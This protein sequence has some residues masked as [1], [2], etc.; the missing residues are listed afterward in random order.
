MLP[1]SETAR[2]LRD[3]TLDLMQLLDDVRTRMH[4]CEQGFQAMLPEEGRFDRLALEAQSLLERYP[5]PAKRPPLFGIPVAVKDI[6]HVRGFPTKAGSALPPEALY[7]EEGPVIQALRSAGA[8]VLGKAHTTE[9]AYFTPS[10]TCNPR[11]PA[12]TPGGSS[13][14]SAAAVAAGYSPLGLGTQT[15]GSVIRPAAFCGVTGFKPSWGRVPTGGIIPFSK[16]VDQVGF[17]TSDVPGAALA[18]RVFCSCWNVA[19]RS[20]SPKVLAVPE[21]PLL[22]CV[23]E[24]A[25]AVFRAVLRELQSLGWKIVAAPVLDDLAEIRAL[26][27]ALA[28][29]DMASAH[30]VWFPQFEHLYGERTRQ[31]IMAGQSVPAE[32]AGAARASMAFLRTRL[33]GTLRQQKF[34]AFVCPS[35]PGAAPLGLSST[36]DPIM[37]LPWT[38]AGLPAVS[39]PAG[40]IDGLPLGMQVIGG[41]NNDEALLRLCEELQRDIVRGTA[42]KA[43]S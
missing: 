37:N 11:N 22:A 34:G 9:F 25:L 13:S 19:P 2:A 5:E 12:H 31:L 6:I 1:L 14:G 40:F 36:G 43:V 30:A 24:K 8:L 26:H 35:A 3:G 15:V 23:D 29:A 42:A 4:A 38:H 28:A 41:F 20:E 10:P 16:S 18:S 7:G 32:Q 39:L 17:F 21:G 27:E 33:D